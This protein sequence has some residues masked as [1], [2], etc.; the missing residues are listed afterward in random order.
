MRLS[1][2]LSPVLNNM[3]TK[4]IALSEIGGSTF[5]PTCSRFIRTTWMLNV[6]RPVLI[7]SVGARIRFL[8]AAEASR[9][10]DHVLRRNVFSR[11]SYERSFYVNRIREF[12]NCSIIEVE[13][14]GD[15]KAV[16]NQGRIV[17]AAVEAACVASTSLY[18]SRRFF[19]AR[20]GITSHRKDVL[21]FT[22]GPSFRHLSASSRREATVHG[23]TVDK[24]FSDRFHRSGLDRLVAEALKPLAAARRLG[25]GLSWLHESR[26]EHS[27]GAA[28]VKLAI[29]Y[30]ALLGGSENEPLR[31]SL[32]ER[33]AFLLSDDLALRESISNLVRAFYDTRSQ[34]VH[35][36]IRKK[37]K[38]A[39]VEQLE[40]AERI[41]LLLL[42]TVASNSELLMSDHAIQ[43]WVER[44]RWGANRSIQRPFRPGDLKR[45]LFRAL[46]G[47]DK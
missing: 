39:S 28:V 3:V 6:Q 24:T 37:S 23:I 18:L 14:Q 31:R 43:E 15:P 27:F 41:L 47:H 13:L 22:I 1:S 26:M 9:I 30:E 34:V 38:P 20:L 29:G 4:Q 40:A 5:D 7:S 36:A 11:H 19:H 32:S 25:Q 12:V 44:Q 21:D 16:V 46:T 17:A 33:S 45:A 8:D 2:V 42:V 10:E 35:G